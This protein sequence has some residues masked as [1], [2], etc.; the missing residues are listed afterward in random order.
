M[1]V[2]FAYHLQGMEQV[3]VPGLLPF[4]EA[5]GN[6]VVLKLAKESPRGSLPLCF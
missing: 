3:P 6:G 1:P 5:A 2:E 4:P